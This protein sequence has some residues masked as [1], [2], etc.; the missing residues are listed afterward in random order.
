MTDFG[1]MLYGTTT[2][3]GSNDDGTVFSFDPATGAEKVLYSF[4]G[5]DGGFPV[6]DLIHGKTLLYGTTVD[7]DEDGTI[8]SVNPETGAEKVYG[9]IGDSNDPFENTRLTKGDR[10]LY[11]VA[12]QSESCYFS[13]AIY[14]IAR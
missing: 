1:N 7:P 11:G 8:F 2:I 3:G 14:S 4:N 13:G 12:T 6:T 5:T 9:N 10:T